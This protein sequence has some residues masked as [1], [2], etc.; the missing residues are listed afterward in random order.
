V[1][2]VSKIEHVLVV[3]RAKAKD[4][5]VQLER[6][7]LL[8]GAHAK[9]MDTLPEGS[10]SETRLLSEVMPLIVQDRGAAK[11]E[12]EFD[13]G[14]FVKT[15]EKNR[16]TK[17]HKRKNKKGYVEELLHEKHYKYTLDIELITLQCTDE[18]LKCVH[19]AVD[20]HPATE[21]V[22]FYYV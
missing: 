20:K 14:L 21:G 18:I 1:K 8:P 12:W 22:S 2:P 3:T 17:G 5:D 4:K 10:T 13:D 19:D 15:R 6:E 16:L 9:P 11:P 7:D